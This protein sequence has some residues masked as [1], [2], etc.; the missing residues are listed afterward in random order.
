MEWE[1][2][3]EEVAT[4]ENGKIT[5]ISEGEATIT[6]KCKDDGEYKATCKVNV[7]SFI[8]DSYVQYEVEYDDIFSGK[9][10]SKNTGWR[11]ITQEQNSDGTYNI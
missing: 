11:L 1:T 10:Y 5:P 9:R 2:S 3:N 4:V 7:E 6:A 8:D